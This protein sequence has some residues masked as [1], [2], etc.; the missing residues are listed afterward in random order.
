MKLYYE[1][2]RLQ[3][4]ENE[5][6]TYD[7]QDKKYGR[8]IHV[9]VDKGFADEAISEVLRRRVERRRKRALKG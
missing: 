7:L 8:W 6:G 9:G 1:D 5:N 2:F 3:V 4:V